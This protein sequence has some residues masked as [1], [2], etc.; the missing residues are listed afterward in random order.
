VFLHELHIFLPRKCPLFSL[1][2]MFSVNTLMHA[3]TTQEQVLDRQ[4]THE[5]YRLLAVVRGVARQQ[6]CLGWISEFS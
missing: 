3:T 4:D 1:R 5:E 2:F 6:A